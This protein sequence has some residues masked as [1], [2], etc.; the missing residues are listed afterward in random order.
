M[1]YTLSMNNKSKNIL[2]ILLAIAALLLALRVVFDS[3]F[4]DFNRYAVE[5]E[6]YKDGPEAYDRNLKA[7][8]EWVKQYKQDHPGATDE[9][10]SA[11]FEAA[12]KK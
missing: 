9:D 2:L 5:R 11:A 3:K 8:G 4:D 12:W 7:L 1:Y 6:Q 10:A